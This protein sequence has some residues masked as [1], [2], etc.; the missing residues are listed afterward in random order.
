MKIKHITVN[1]YIS[2]NNCKEVD[3]VLRY[4]ELEPLDLFNIGSLLKQ[5]FGVVKDAQHLFNKSGATFDNYINFMY[6]VF[7][8]DL[9]RI[10][11]E[12]VYK[13]HQSRLYLLDQVN[14]INKL[15]SDSLGHSPS[16]EEESAGIERFH[17]YEHYPQFRNLA[18]GGDYDKI[19]AIKKWPYEFCFMELKYSADIKD[20]EN[21]L[22]RIRQNKI[23]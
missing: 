11:N 21:E 19:E 7:D 5:P 12:S 13:L 8:V 22:F 23:K 2:G 3:Y 18:G 10:G 15:E 6:D 14:I 16:V 4:G 9:K 1:Q 20:F 17:K